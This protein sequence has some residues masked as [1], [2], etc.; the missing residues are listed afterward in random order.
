ME[1]TFGD[2]V[3]NSD[4][5]EL[6]GPDGLVAIEQKPL[7]LLF[8]LAQNADRVVTKDDVIDHVWGGRIVSDAT[9]STAVKQAR[10]AVGDTGSDQKIIKT[11]H[12]RGFRFIAGAPS[13]SPRKLQEPS[14]E[15]PIGSAKPSIAVMRFQPFGGDQI[16]AT[17]ADAIPSE[18][19]TSLSRLHWLQITA[20]GSSFRFSPDEIVPEEV[21][22]KL[23]A[24]YLVSGTV[25]SIGNMITITVDLL[26][27]ADGR[28][29]WSDRFAFAAS[30]AQSARGGIVSSV[31]SALELV[32]P[33]V[34]AEHTK[35]LP[36]TSFDAWSH[37]HLGLRH[38]YRFSHEDNQRA[39]EHFKEAIALDPDFSR[40]HGGISF[41]YWQQ[42]FMHFGDDRREL[43][44]KAAEFARNAL[45]ADGEDPFANYNMGRAMWLSGDLDAG[46][47]WLNR[48][49][50]VNPNYAQ[51]HYTRGL[52]LLLSGEPDAAIGSA[53]KAMALSPLDPLFY[54]MLSTR[55]MSQL[56][57]GNNDAAVRLTNKAVNSPGAHFYI[58]MIAATAQ[59]LAG[60]HTRAERTARL[61]K[62]EMPSANK[63]MFFQAFPFAQGE[64]RDMMSKSLERLGF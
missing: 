9:I 38:M 28:Q 54:A 4:R 24:R 43:L 7:E 6:A 51:G 60:E 57:L 5:A 34:E 27:S 3:L 37:Y 63:E 47:D 16:G 64:T 36:A 32:V 18:I 22:P 31:I 55:A 53:E 33:R 56:A 45:T 40:A 39:A 42:A 62:N 46:V 19:I 21:G 41:T 61:V 23:N 1:W 12:G 11:I 59:E 29:L 50:Y 10:R 52:T 8:F 58:Q 15:A 13:A 49:V 20:R 25:E 2:Y 48:A 35:D 44:N 30:D 17:V 26:S 14:L